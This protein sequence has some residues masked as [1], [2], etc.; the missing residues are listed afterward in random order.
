MEHKVWTVASFSLKR[1]QGLNRRIWKKK[2]KYAQGYIAEKD[3]SKKEYS[4][5]PNPYSF[6]MREGKNIENA[7]PTNLLEK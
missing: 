3:Q 1:K 5:P 4:S 7:V 6:G 2:P